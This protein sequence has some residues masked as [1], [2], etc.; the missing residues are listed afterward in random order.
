MRQFQKNQ[1]IKGSENMDLLNKYNEFLNDND[2]TFFLVEAPTGSGKTYCAKKFISQNYK[3]N[4][5][6][7]ITNQHTLLPKVNDFLEFLGDDYEDFKNNFLYLKSTIDTFKENFNTN[8]LNHDFL[9]SNKLLIKEIEKII[10]ALRDK[11]YGL[12]EYLEKD[13]YE[14]EIRFRNSIKDFCRKNKETQSLKEYI[15]TQD[16]IVNLYPQV[17]LDSK[18]VIVMTSKK[19]FL[20]A[21]RATPPSTVIERAL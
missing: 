8:L 4:K 21:S 3:T 14:A 15:K 2:K 10:N 20:Q 17:L 18:K 9:E 16:W 19:F 7:F 13:F 1:R 5:I 11:T 12:Q 6:I